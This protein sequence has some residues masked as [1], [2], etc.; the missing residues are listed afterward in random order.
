MADDLGI[1]KSTDRATAC[2]VG[3][4][5]YFA[6]ITQTYT[7]MKVLRAALPLVEPYPDGVLPITERIP[8]TAFF[9]GGDGLWKEEGAIEFPVGGVMVL[10][11]NFDSEKGYHR[12]LA[13][14]KEN[15]KGPTWGRL[16]YLLGSAGIDMKACFFTNFFMGLKAGD[17]STGE[18]PGMRD[19]E[20]VRR[21]QQFFLLQVSLMQPRMIITLGLQV[22]KLIAPLSEDL[23]CW[24]DVRSVEDLDCA[25]FVNGVKFSDDSYPAIVV[26]LLHPSFAGMNLR[27]RNHGGYTGD[28]VEHLILMDATSAML[29]R[30]ERPRPDW[31]KPFLHYDPK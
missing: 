10:G 21:C 11:H 15:L 16:D 25:A 26:G 1:G 6:P 8:G 20:F 17:K 9:P 31:A 13:V 18:F 7:H 29:W 2:F 14:R 24:K 4:D 19:K 28:Q 3:R 30:E 23:A 5:S 22:P 12:S 27:L